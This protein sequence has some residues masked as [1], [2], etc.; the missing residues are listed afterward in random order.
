MIEKR[1]A[2]EFNSALAETFPK[3]FALALSLSAIAK[4]V[5]PQDVVERLAR[6]SVCELESDF[7]EKALH[8]F[9]ANV[10][11][12]AMFTIWTLRKINDL[13]FQITS[14]KVD[15]AKVNEDKDFCHQFNFAAL[16][17][18]FSLDCLEMALRLKQP[19]YPE[20]MPELINGLRSMVNA[21]AWARRGA[22]LRFPSVEMLPLE[23]DIS[24]DEDEML[25]RASMHGMSTMNED[26][27]S[28]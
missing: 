20:V 11:D 25:L 19:I 8:A 15:E 12:Q 4:T 6:E 18:Y 14:T 3:Y 9:G 17:A 27:D 1:T 22:E 23:T 26:D 10:R 21:Y 13:L 5:V 2:A 28:H 24:D 16:H 7:R